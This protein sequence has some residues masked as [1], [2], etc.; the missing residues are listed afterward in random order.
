[1]SNTVP[2]L[3]QR[4]ETA[5]VA[6]EKAQRRFASERLA[7]E[8]VVAEKRRIEDTLQEYLKRFREAQDKIY[9]L[10]EKVCRAITFYYR[11]IRTLPTLSYINYGPRCFCT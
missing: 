7:K 2:F 4:A 5:E 6:K 11:K 8:D 9:Q 10:K 3:K 1:M